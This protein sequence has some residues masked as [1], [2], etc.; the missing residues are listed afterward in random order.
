[1][2]RNFIYIISSIL[3][4]FSGIVIYGVI[5][6]L[7]E[8]TL[9][10]AMNKRNIEEI[11]NPSIIVDRKNYTLELYSDTIMVKTYNVVFGRNNNSTKTSKNDFVTPLGN[12]KICS[13]D[14][15]NIYYKKLILNYPNIK[16][17]A[18]ALRIKL[19]NRDQYLAISNSINS[20]ECSNKNTPLS[21]DIGIQGTGEYNLIFKNLPFV[22]NWTNGS[23]ALSNENIDELLTAVRIGTKIT[24]KN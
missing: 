23:I 8:T 9:L 7:R 14:Y 2:F 16:D 10:E 18:E 22:F 20:D 1:M 19:I 17:A 15:N 4:F 21:A 24:I 13:I 12:Y 5:L 11:Q 3:L 6:N